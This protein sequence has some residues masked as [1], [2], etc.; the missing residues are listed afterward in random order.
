M[1]SKGKG[2][3]LHSLSQTAE[4]SRVLLP[5]S[6]NRMRSE[7]LPFPLQGAEEAGGIISR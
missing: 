6:V 2:L 3:Y 5:A 7:Q 4:T 1:D